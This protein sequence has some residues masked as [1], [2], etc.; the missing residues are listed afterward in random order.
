MQMLH[1]VF[2]RY[3]LRQIDPAGI[4]THVSWHMSQNIAERK[5]QWWQD[6]LYYNDGERWSDGATFYVRRVGD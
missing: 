2:H 3:E 1:R 6:S 4:N 5:R